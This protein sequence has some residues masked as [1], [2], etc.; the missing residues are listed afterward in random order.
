MPVQSSYAETLRAGV[1][2]AI[3]N[4]EPNN[5]ISRTVEGAA[6]G[7][8]V[9]VAQG[10]G[11][12][13]ILAL[14]ALAFAA[15]VAADAGNTGN[16]TVTMAAPATGPG[17]KLGDYRLV[18]IEP[19]AAGGVFSVEDPAGVQIGRATVGVL[20]D[21]EIRFTINDGAVD[22]AA[23]DAFTVSVTAS[24]GTAD[25]L[26]VTVREHS[27]RPET[28]NSFAVGESARVMT[29][30][31]IWVTAGEAVAAGDPVYVTPA[32]STFKK[33]A[34]DN[35]AIPDARYDTSAALGELVQL[36]LGR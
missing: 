35:V 18:A 5:L 24:A 23:G 2:G 30:G 26:G 17:V 4:T 1:A 9:P 36:R 22:F 12:K 33:T 25:V 16:G 21:N 14:S 11:D 29:R 19:V 27:V 32:D 15:A 28:P 13:G 20:F 10:A 6:I 3:V 8:G 31:V 7:F 34:A